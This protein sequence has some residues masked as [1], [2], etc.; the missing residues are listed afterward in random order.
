M[1]PSMQRRAFLAA[2][3]ISIPSIALASGATGSWGSTAANEFH[4]QMEQAGKHLKSMR[5][6]MEDL[7]APGARE[8]AAFL[9]NQVTIL[10]AQCIV[11]A[12]QVEVP[13]RSADKYEGEKE[14][15][16]NKVRMSLADS[17]DAS[18]ALVSAL[19]AGKDER[20]VNYYG[21]LRK[22]RNAGHDAFKED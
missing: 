4:D 6:H 11:V 14:K 5:S 1:N 13:T 16:T 8:E 22:E 12:D 20:A 7:T 10:L 18:N 9:A 2:G 3:A 19:L 21:K 15:F 17:V